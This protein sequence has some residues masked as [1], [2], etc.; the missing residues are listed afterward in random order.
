MKTKCFRVAGKH[1]QSSQMSCLIYFSVKGRLRV[2][3]L[4]FSECS[5]IVASSLFLSLLVFVC[6]LRLLSMLLLP[7]WRLLLFAKH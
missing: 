5:K 2:H 6:H 1:V 3:Q 4:I 7:L